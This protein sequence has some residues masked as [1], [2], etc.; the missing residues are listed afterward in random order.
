MSTLTLSLKK[1]NLDVTIDRGVVAR[2]HGYRRT[3]N[4]EDP[5][6]FREVIIPAAREGGL[7]VDIEP[8]RYRVQAILPSGQILQ[9]EV[10]V[11]DGETTIAF[12]AAGSSKEWLSWQ[13]FEGSPRI[14]VPSSTLDTIHEANVPKLAPS[15][16]WRSI[17]Q[18]V[19]FLKG[20]ARSEAAATGFPGAFPDVW[21][22]VRNAAMLAI[23]E[24]PA[25]TGAISWAA[26]ANAAQ[27]VDVSRAWSPPAADS[28]LRSI[29]IQQEGPLS[30]WRLE[31][32]SAEFE[33][34]FW[35]F[36]DVAD[37]VEIASIPLPWSDELSSATVELLVDSADGDIGIRSSMVVRD[38]VL[39]G[40]LAYLG[41]GRLANVRPLIES[42]MDGNLIENTIRGKTR[43]PLAACA[44]A[45]VGL[46]IYE[47][48]ERERW[49][50]WLP[51]IMNWFPQIPDGAIIHARR[52]IQR[53]RS[54][55]E[56]G[57]ALAALKEAYNRGIPFFTAGVLGLRD[58]LLMFSDRD[59]E[60]K[61]MLENVSKVATR[62]D[63]GQAFT[64]LSFPK[65]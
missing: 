9:E 30:L 27:A 51:N 40:M 13:K 38:A 63:T 42:L 22:G 21:R 55:A 65:V 19:P 4:L 20:L 12:S 23:Y 8:G 33:C 35:A 52:M 48:W 7:R 60:A 57:L 53:P 50:S 3:D 24:Q 25:A 37:V 64:V 11:D 31:G 28:G 49:D 6:Y 41:R 58:S 45:Y 1:E 43:N 34:R 56:T 59:G 26:A 36:S 29:R 32:G 17:L 46:A 15:G 16:V 2:I 61:Q 10:Q 44:A 54:A 39:G 18:N 62:I 5:P 47:P 14:A